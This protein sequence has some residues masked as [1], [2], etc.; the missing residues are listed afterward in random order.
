[1]SRTRFDTI[2]CGVA[3]ALEQLGDWWTLLIIRDALLGA[4]RF[5]QFET[6]LGI[7]KN[8]LSD[9]LSR[10]VEHDVLAKERL[11]EPGHRYEYKLTPKGRDLWIV[12]TAMRLWSDKWIFGEAKVPFVFRERESGRE[13]ARLIAVDADGIPVEASD[14]EGAPGPGWPRGVEA[15]VEEP[16]ASPPLEPAR[17]RRK[18]I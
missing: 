1:M 4:T 15:P 12:I 2:N 6:N 11:A 3:Q 17:R 14:L 13:V 10:L 5:Q 8:V 16:W 9:R 7:A 18:T